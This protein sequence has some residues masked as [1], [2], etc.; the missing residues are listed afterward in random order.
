[1]ILG[2]EGRV[3]VAGTWRCRS[4]WECP[5]CARMVSRRN[6]AD[7]ELARVS[8]LNAGGAVLLVT[9]TAP[10][11][12]TDDLPSLRKA[13]TKAWPRVW[14]G[15]S[16]ELA[17][18][19]LGLEGT[20]RGLEVTHSWANGWHPHLHVAMFVRERPDAAG[21]AEL[22]AWILARWSRYVVAEG[23]REP[24]A[25]HG[26]TV[27]ESWAI[28]YVAKQ[29]LAQEV[30]SAVTKE[31]RAGN[32]APIQL[33]DGARQGREAC[34]VAWNVYARGMRR[35]KALEWSRGL[36][37]RLTGRVE[38]EPPPADVLAEVTPQAWNRLTWVQREAY[39]QA[40][41]DYLQKRA[42]DPPDEPL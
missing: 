29:G 11:D 39:R 30:G 42:P 16:G 9:V 18:K 41:A 25:E 7:L 27:S 19:R 20:V 8:W 23:L 38:T 35:A 26:V 2:R 40:W 31:A 28:A 21:L 37:A 22:R 36:R 15:R 1:M 14:A 5:L 12:R 6:V 13:V 33:L 17:R 32:L 3:H 10:H 24:S 4:I 34:R